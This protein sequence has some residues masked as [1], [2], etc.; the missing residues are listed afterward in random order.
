MKNKK[1]CEYCKGF[2]D[3]KVYE[4]DKEIT[5]R[6]KVFVCDKCRSEEEDKN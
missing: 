3:V 2:E 4:V 5:G 1:Y 6:K